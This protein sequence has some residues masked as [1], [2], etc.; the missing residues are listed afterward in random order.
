MSAVELLLAAMVMVESGGDR[1]AVGD[2]GKS[3]GPLQ[4]QE[5]YFKDAMEQLTREERWA[6]K[7]LKYEDVKNPV[8]AKLIVRAYWRR[9]VPDALKAGDLEVLARTHNGG[10]RG[11]SK[12]ATLGYWDKVKKAMEP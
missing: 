3:I 9:Y 2:G 5:P 10:P 6:S 11:A 1:N 12:K 4:I 7:S 8:L